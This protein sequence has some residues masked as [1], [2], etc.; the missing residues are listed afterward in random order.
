MVPKEGVLS[1][2]NPL[3]KRFVEIFVK[4]DDWIQ[5]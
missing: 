3:I 5:R 2:K 1:C 4:E